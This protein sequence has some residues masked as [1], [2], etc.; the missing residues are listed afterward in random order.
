MAEL[1]MSIRMPDTNRLP[2]P[3]VSLPQAA[4]QGKSFLVALLG[5]RMQYAVPRILFQAGRLRR[6]FTDLD[7]RSAAFRC[8]RLLPSFCLPQAV[9]RLMNRYPPEI[10]RAL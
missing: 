2:L 4:G 10:P 8:L 5:A 6:L 3:P 9:M 7:G 1:A